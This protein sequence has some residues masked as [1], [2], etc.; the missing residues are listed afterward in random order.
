MSDQFNSPYTRSEAEVDVGLRA[1][2]RRM[3]VQMGA[4]VA[5]SGL[6]V[7]FMMQWIG[8]NPEAYMAIRSSGLIW[9]IMLS[10]LAIYLI[11]NFGFQRLSHAA[12][13]ACFWSFAGLMAVSFSMIYTNYLGD[14]NTIANA[15]FGAAA[16][17][18]GAALYGYTTNRDLTSIGGLLIMALIGIILVSI[19][20]V[21]VMQSSG[22]DL[23]ISIGI[24]LIFTAFTAY[25]TQN[26]KMLYLQHGDSMMTQKLAVLGALL[27]YYNFVIIF[28]YLLILFSGRD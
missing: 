3:F 13:Q 8:A 2:M 16:A 14:T 5:F 24:V 12:L 26:M 18:L 15:F 1:F 25:D 6:V 19:L 21:F 9:V 11:A 23:L 28:K 17:F 27:L 4:G 10:P 22:L 7:Y 20:N